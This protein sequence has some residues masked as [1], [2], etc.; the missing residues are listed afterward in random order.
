MMLHFHPWR[1]RAVASI[2]AALALFTAGTAA[3]Q[4]TYT[5][6]EEDLVLL[7]LQV[8]KYRLSSEIRGYQTPGGVCVDLADVIQS[9]NLPIRLDRKSRRATGWIF[10][11]SQKFTIERDANTVQIVNNTRPLQPGELY[12]SPEGWCVDTAA[13]SGWLGVTIHADLRD[14]VLELDSESP[15]PFMEALERRSRAA[16]LRPDSSHDLSTYPQARQ[17]YAMWRAPS[18]DVMA[19]TDFRSGSGTQN[20]TARYEIYAAGEIAHASFDM[21]LAS[22]I[23]GVPNSLRLRAYRM[24]PDGHLLGPL[25]ATQVI[26]GDVEMP[27]GNIAGAP[28]VGRGI[29]LSNRALNRPTR[30]GSTILRGALPLGWDAELYRNGQLLAFQGGSSD[31]RYEF[32]VNLIYGNNDLEVVL[33]G[34]QGQVRRESQAIPVGLGAIA[35]GKLEYWAGVIQRN[36]DLINFGSDPPGGWLDRG[37][38]YAGGLQYGL[39]RRTVIGASGH[40]LYLD[41][42]RRDYAELNLQRALGPILLNLS[43]AQEF[44][45]G[46]AYRA[47]LL[48]RL[49]TINIQAE[50]FFVDGQYESGLVGANE[51]SSHQFQV[52]TV[53]HAGRTP[54]PL[55]AGFR[56]T[57]QRDGRKVNEM[58]MRASLILPRMALTGFVIRRTT[59]GGSN[60][61]DGFQT[62]VLA[63]TR[64]LGL[65]ARGEVNYRLTG[66]RQGFDS[67]KL[68]LE[69]ALD[70][71]SDLRLDVEHTHRNGITSFEMGYVRQFRQFALR[72]SGRMDTN[73]DMG[74]SLTAAFS[75]GPDPLG[76][77]WRMSGDK[78]AERGEAAVSVFLDQNGDGVRSPGEEAL[79]GVGITAGQHGAADPTDAEGHAFVQGLQPYDKVLVS[80]DESTLPDPFL[81]P[82][83]KGVVVTPRPGVAAVVEIAVSPTGEV[84]GLLTSPEGTSLAGVELELVDTQ[85]AVAADTLS[86]YDGF[87]LFERVIYGRY[88]LRIADG[89]ARALG[90]TLA[91]GVAQSV[92]IGPD[93]ATER[94]G[95]LQLRPALTVAQAASPPGGA[96]P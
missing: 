25:K 70:D 5:P 85:G 32:E 24:D 78:L 33:Y 58:L 23:S 52:D 87:F 38:Q 15:L 37:W 17:P 79:E 88:S 94:L 6:N 29:F 45:S 90:L 77:G 1:R 76:G 83:G 69:K 63:N 86:E 44:G 20:V 66:P 12:D 47:E 27:S 8:K 34:P 18:V 56:R 68:T 89:S 95:T 92:E 73:G 49:G 57:T 55:S 71:R 67:A 62:G 46:R 48:G 14:S 82:R 84:E 22:D 16:R 43:G 30:F 51:R 7:Q 4:A 53:V 60:D 72:G 54:V 96:S 64:F 81:V 65:T 21:R 3:A 36:R 40:S 2:A 42:A 91:S 31:G 50:S 35:P 75:F 13:L 74:L 26:G 39:D 59:Q 10:A 61:D 93:N 41:L 28:G 9:L 11:E 19:R 80:I